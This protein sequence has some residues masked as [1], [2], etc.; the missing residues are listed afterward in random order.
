MYFLV[1]S[2]ALNRL[3]KVLTNKRFL[4]DVEKLSHHFQT[5]SMESFHSVIQRFAPKKV[6]FPFIG[7]LCRYVQSIRTSACS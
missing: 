5:S 7:M 3:D 6:V 2:L 4:T 1:G